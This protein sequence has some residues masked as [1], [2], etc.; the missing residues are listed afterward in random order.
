M[1]KLLVCLELCT[2]A[3]RLR[4]LT[5]KMTCIHLEPPKQ[6]YNLKLQSGVSINY[7]IK[8]ESMDTPRKINME[9]TNHPFGKENDLPNLHD[10]VPC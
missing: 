7:P 6:L 9:P 2:N 10:Y 4:V 8:D 5:G 1:S 3:L